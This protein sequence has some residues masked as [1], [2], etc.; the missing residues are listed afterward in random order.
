MGFLRYWTL[1]N[2]PLFVLAAPMLAVMIKSS[3]WAMGMETNSMPQV[4]SSSMTVPSAKTES[5]LLRSLAV[6]QLLLALLALTTAHVQIIT[7]LS[8]GYCIW[9]F[10][11]AALLSNSNTNGSVE[12]SPGSTPINTRR[13]RHD[14]ASSLVM[15]IV[16]YAVVQAGLFS[17]FLPPA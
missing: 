4:Q 10:W 13:L 7:R 15:Y 9:Y 17:S 6:P 3:I 8:S 16:I 5:H 12:K 1:S 11:L 2:I 14:G